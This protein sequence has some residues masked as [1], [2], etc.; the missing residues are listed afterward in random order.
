MW[1]RPGRSHLEA[2]EAGGGGAGEFDGE[3]AVDDE[4][5]A[6][7]EAGEVGDEKQHGVGDVLGVA[8]AANGVLKG[9]AGVEF[10]GGG[11]GGGFVLDGRS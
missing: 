4:G 7:D 6:G 2:G 3:A 9:L 5:F 11:L 1:G 8:A 10:G